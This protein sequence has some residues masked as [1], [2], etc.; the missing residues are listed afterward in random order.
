LF[1]TRWLGDDAIWNPDPFTFQLVP[2]ARHPAMRAGAP[3][4]DELFPV[5]W[6]RVQ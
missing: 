5:V 2:L 4:P 1:S 6:R 3:P